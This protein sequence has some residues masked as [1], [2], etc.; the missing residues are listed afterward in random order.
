VGPGSASLRLRAAEKSELER[1]QD[2]AAAAELA[3][4]EAEVA[5]GLEAPPVSSTD[6]IDGPPKG[7]CFSRPL[8]LPGQGGARATRADGG[9]VGK[10]GG[11]RGS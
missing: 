3:R 11:E 7:E 2:G 6:F 10:W 9:G 1:G 5:R 4:L 8:A